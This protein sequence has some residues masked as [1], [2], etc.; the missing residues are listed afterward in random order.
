MNYNDISKSLKNKSKEDLL[1]ILEKLIHSNLCQN[2]NLGKTDKN[3][4]RCQFS[5][6]I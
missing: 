5:P 1:Q 6:R 2:T 4:S 3:D